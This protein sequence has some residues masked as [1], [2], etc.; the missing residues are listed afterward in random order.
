M[1]LRVTKATVVGKLEISE[2][3][4]DDDVVIIGAAKTYN[5]YI[6]AMPAAR[7]LAKQMNVDL[8]LVTPTGPQG[9]ITADD[10]KNHLCSMLL[11]LSHFL[12]QRNHCMACVVRWH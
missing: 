9:L 1:K 12:G 7:V 3:K 8:N 10:V 5:T 4:W 11:R 6:K 2:K